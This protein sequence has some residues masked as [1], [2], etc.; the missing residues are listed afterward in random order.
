LAN[1]R[2][3]LEKYPAEK[4]AIIGVCPDERDRNKTVRSQPSAVVN[5]QKLAHRHFVGASNPIVAT[6]RARPSSPA[7]LI[8][9]S[10]N[11]VELIDLFEAAPATSSPPARLPRFIQAIDRHVSRSEP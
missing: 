10:G 8:D 11:I 4:L 9:G 6:Y 2:Q 1:V 5:S 3:V 7:L